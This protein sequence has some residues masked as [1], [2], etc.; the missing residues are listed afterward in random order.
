MKNSTCMVPDVLRGVRMSHSDDLVEVWHGMDT[1]AIACG[2]CA[3]YYLP[4]VFEA[5]REVVS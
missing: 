3:T 5:H 2:F 4:E 1:P